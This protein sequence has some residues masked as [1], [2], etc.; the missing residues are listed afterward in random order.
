V[1]ADAQE[2]DSMSDVRDEI[3]AATLERSNAFLGNFQTPI[4]IKV[5][6]CPDYSALL[7]GQHGQ[8]V[9]LD[10][11]LKL[12]TR[13]GR[14]ILCGR[15]ASGKSALLH[16][17]AI[18]ADRLG[19][20][21]FLL[22][23]AQ[24]DQAATEV[25]KSVRENA[26]DA[27]DFLLRRFGASDHDIT[28]AEFLPVSIEKL[29]LLDGLNETPGSTADEILTAC[30]QIASVMV[31]AS[32]IVTDRL[33][34]R[35]LDT[36]SKWVFAMPLPVEK[37]EVDRLV[38]G[39]GVPAEVEV[40]L[41]SPFFL[42]RAI[43][44]E[45]RG[46][47][48]ATLKNMFEER[49]GLNLDGLSAAAQAAFRAYELDRSRTFDAARFD[50]LGQPEVAN[51]LLAGGILVHASENRLAFFH[52]W[53]HDYLASK[54]V[55]AHPEL[56]SFENRHR[57]FDDL[58]FKANSFDAIAFALELLDINT[59]GTFLRA[60]YDWNPYA[61]GYAL[62]EAGI[63][64]DD[65]PRDVRLIMIAMLAEKRFDPLFYTAR[66]AADALD[67]LKDEDAL[68]LRSTANRSQLL[69][70]VGA[71]SSPSKEFT[72]WVTFFTARET[73]PTPA[74]LVEALTDDVS[75]IGWTAANVLKRVSLTEGG[76]DAVRASATDDRPVVRWRAVHALGGIKGD[77]SVAALLDRLDN[78]DD[79][80]V[81]YGAARSLVEIASGDAETLPRI[82]DNI[83]E[84]LGSIERSDKVLGEFSRAVFLSRDCAPP[85]WSNEMSR[86]FY[87][88]AERTNDMTVAEHWS[89]LAS[90]LR[91]HHRSEPKLAA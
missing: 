84:R 37:V 65:V 52:H 59:S 56:W 27:L 14:V 45:L 41:A 49:G 62:A 58:T 91:V 87:R 4:E 7:R 47:P 57:V 86:I 10:D 51:T 38:N 16:R 19:F 61:A 34:R 70:V 60:V 12:A 11:L 80:N 15:G 85:N 44:G 5:A 74:G 31:G 40:L 66:K 25:W 67:L 29:F 9:S 39:L 73:E 26:R 35:S 76:A 3:A 82:V 75:V 23:L 77:K 68:K 90:R 48:L 22:N 42:D 72:K 30:D 50:E 24:W 55:V 32:V 63:G 79:E 2:E 83:I 71:I 81:R 78:D 1:L 33:V 6:Q 36:E 21:P 46:S 69:D 43:L 18:W 89:K 13:R 8:P 20:A 54:H 28:D 64:V 88:L 53:Y 17:L